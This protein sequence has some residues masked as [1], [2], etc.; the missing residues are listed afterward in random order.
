MTPSTVS[1]ALGTEVISGTRT[2]SR[3]AADAHA[4]RFISDAETDDL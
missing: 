4:V 1:G 3:T 2:I